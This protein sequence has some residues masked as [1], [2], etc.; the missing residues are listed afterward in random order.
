VLVVLEVILDAVINVRDL[1]DIKSF[2]LGAEILF[3]LA[4]PSSH[5]FP[6]LT[7]V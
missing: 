7:M 5:Q 4:P 1:G 2:V 6:C 3:N